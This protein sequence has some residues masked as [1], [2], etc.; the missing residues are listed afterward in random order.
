MPYVYT[1]V[2]QVNADSLPLTRPMYVAYPNEE[3]AY[4]SSQEYL[5]GDNLLAAPI[6]MPGVGPHHVGWQVVWFP[7]GDDWFNL[8]TGEHYAGGTEQLVAADLLQSGADLLAHRHRQLRE[9][10]T[11]ALD[12]LA[13]NL[14][15]W[16]VTRPRGG[17]NLWCRLPRA[18]S[19]ELVPTAAAHD[20]LLA[21]GPSFAPE[22]GLN[23][24]LRIP[25]T[26]PAELLTEAIRRV[27]RAWDETVASQSTRA[28]RGVAPTL[29]A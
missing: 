28:A 19:S 21:P 8:F 2:H 14:P 26:Q 23:S 3:R 20:V 4:H 11:A 1:S 17:L 7:G 13:E 15:S 18:L 16:E 25:Y 22:G 5:F 27:A 12:A 29:V 6:A 9:S 10:R 24:Y